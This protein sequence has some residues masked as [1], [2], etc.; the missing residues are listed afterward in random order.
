MSIDDQNNHP[1][2]KSAHDR[3]M[4]AEE[5]QNIKA[6]TKY[7]EP[8]NPA[9]WSAEELGDHY[10]QESV[11]QGRYVEA[12]VAKCRRLVDDIDQIQELIEESIVHAGRIKFAS[13]D[14]T[15]MQREA[16]RTCD[17]LNVVLRKI[18]ETQKGAETK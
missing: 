14:G 7:P 15:P 13:Y 12:L 5:Q 11:D 6:A 3:F 9:S 18:R 2:Y 4:R 17:V 1:L 16:E 8:L 10:A